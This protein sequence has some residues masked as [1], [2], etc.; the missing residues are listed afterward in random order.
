MKPSRSS[1]VTAPALGGRLY[2]SQDGWC[3][4]AP[5]STGLRGWYRWREDTQ[6]WQCLGPASYPD[7]AELQP[8]RSVC[9]LQ[10]GR[11]RLNPH[12]QHEPELHL[13]LDES[14][15]DGQWIQCWMCLN[16]AW[17]VGPAA[18]P[19]V[20]RRDRIRPVPNRD[21]ARAVAQGGGQLLEAQ[22][23]GS[24][25][26]VRWRR[27]GRE[28]NSLVDRNFN[29]LQAGF[30]LSGQDRRQDPTT[31][32]SLLEGEESRYASHGGWDGYS[33]W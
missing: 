5:T 1:E 15:S 12:L 2:L 28:I 22:A 32:V 10:A 11:G 9:K 8:L 3:W 30:C 21:L 16:K 24:N 31:L 14:F 4:T 29:V 19:P 7:L 27:G 23:R 33:G 20:R 6:G 13:C 18:A 26:I 25:W 17:V